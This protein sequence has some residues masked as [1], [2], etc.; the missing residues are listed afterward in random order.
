M[1]TK[2]YPLGP[3]DN[4][5]LTKI[6]KIIFGTGC[7]VVSIFWM[8]FKFKETDTTISL[9]VTI[10]FL[11]GFGLYQIWSGLG[12]A[13]RYIELGSETI[14]LKKNA[15]LPA[16]DIFAGEIENIES[17]PLNVVFFLRT[18]R[19]ILLRFGTT[20]YETN[21]KIIDEIAVFAEANNIPFKIV[22]EEI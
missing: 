13:T 19:R 21:E 18:K 4:N 17:R 2:Y 3:G 12:Y 9:W 7:L 20:Y 22:E 5:L 14:R 15:L 8:V 16:S 6:F 10:I 1:E 11:A